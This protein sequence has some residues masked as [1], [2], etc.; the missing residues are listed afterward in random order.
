MVLRRS[1]IYLSPGK[2]NIRCV[3]G[4]GVREHS[5]YCRRWAMSSACIGFRNTTTQKYRKLPTQSAQLQTKRFP[6]RAP[7]VG[8]E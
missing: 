7:F 3:E 8:I 4:H 1:G 2:P 6:L 5:S